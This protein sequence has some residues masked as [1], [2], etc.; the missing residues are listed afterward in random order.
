[1][2]TENSIRMLSVKDI[3]AMKVHAVANRGARR[4]FIDLGEILQ[5]MPLE[6]VLAS[7]HQQFQAI[8]DGV[9]AYHKGHDFFY[10]RRI[11]AAESSRPEWP[12]MG[13]FQRHRPAGR[14][15]A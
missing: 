3:A 5:K 10:R 12:E 13:K 9:S 4:D 1:M 6:S 2:L 8:A 14:K 7:Y 11:N 15:K